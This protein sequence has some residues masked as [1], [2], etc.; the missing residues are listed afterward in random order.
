MVLI[1]DVPPL[2]VLVNVSHVS[3]FGASDGS[4]EFVPQDAEGTVQYSIDN[5]ANFQFDPLFTDLP[6]NITYLLVALDEAGKLF[7][8]RRKLCTSE[9]TSAARGGSRSSTCCVHNS[10][11]QKK[12][13]KYLEL[14]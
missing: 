6:G 10:K 13:L 1:L 2:D 12:W 3:C 9:V 14:P 4:I 11:K 7:T 8:G 5:G